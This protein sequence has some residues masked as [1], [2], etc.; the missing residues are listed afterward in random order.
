MFTRALQIPLEQRKSFFLFGPRGTGKTTWLA[1]RVPDALF[2]NLL[3]SDFYL[4]LSANPAHLR[5]LI[6]ERPAGWIVIDEIQRVPELLNEVHDLI[7]SKGH[8]FILTGSSARK[9]RRGA[10][11]LLAG[12]AL[13]YH[14]HP[15]IAAEQGEAF[16][17]A[18]SLNLGHLPARFSEPDPAR[19]VRDYVQTYLREEIMQGGLTRNIGN[20]SRFLEVASFSQG[21]VLNISDVAR[22]AHIQRSVA[23]SYVSILED[24]LI[25]VRLPVFTRRSKRQLITHSKF[26]YFDAGVFRAIRPTGPLDSA[27]EIDGPALETL[28][29]QELRAVNDYHALGY[30]LHFWRTK[31][32]LEV[33]FVLYG[34]RGLLALAVKRA[35]GVNSVDLRALR[36]F[37]K[38]YPEASCI[39]LYGGAEHLVLDGIRILPIAGALRGLAQL[40]AGNTGQEPTPAPRG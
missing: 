15:L 29:L 1:H 11:N 38:D 19:Y 39:V 36:E 26:Y 23:E 7:E 24:L 34:P 3:R 31:H 9:L 5:A 35:K 8:S 18:N 32:G 14:M 30:D 37:R 25:A 27:A 33:D 13:T 22:D 10:V 6:G 40:L 17:L 2:I 16:D 21:S 20:F 28:V 4:P 12:R